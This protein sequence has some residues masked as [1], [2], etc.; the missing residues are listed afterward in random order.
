M[1]AKGWH[2]AL[3]TPYL[4][5]LIASW[6]VFGETTDDPFITFRYA[7]NICSGY[8]P[9]YNIGEHVEG[10]TSALH[11]LFCVL[12][13]VLLPGIG[14]LLKAKLFSLGCGL[15]TI[16]LTG[17]LASRLH[18]SLPALLAA[19]MLLACNI[20]FAIA[21][22][23]ALETTLFTALLLAAVTAFYDELVREKGNLSSAL[24]FLACLAR[25]EALVYAAALIAFRC[26][27]QRRKSLP[28]AFVGQWLL[29]FA[30]PLALFFCFRLAYYGYLFPNTYYAKA[31]AP[32]YGI[33]NGLLYLRRPFLPSLGASFDSV[34][35]AV[36]TIGFWA[37][38]LAGFWRKRRES[39]AVLLGLL[40]LGNLVFLL[41][42][43]GDW[44]SGCRFLIPV[45][46]YI[47]LL[48]VGALTGTVQVGE[49]TQQRRNRPLRGIQLGIAAL[50]MAA[51]G[52]GYVGFPLG[53]W[54]Q[55]GMPVRDDA[56]LATAT[57]GYAQTWVTIG[58]F[59]RQAMPPGTQIAYSEAGYAAYINRD[60]RFLD[61]FGLTD[62]EIAHV[63]GVE[64]CS[65]GVVTMFWNPPGDPVQGILR[66]RAPD[67]VVIGSV[68]MPSPMPLI[69]MQDYEPMP[70]PPAW[71]NALA[72]TQFGFYRR[73]KG[74]ISE[75]PVSQ[76]E[77]PDFILDKL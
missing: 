46:P 32:L 11:L 77:H 71:K 39:S 33:T 26:V 74:E 38:A 16:W 29:C 36:L 76:Y 3:V 65:F 61:T 67:F 44:M 23:N 15:A 55:R 12:L 10:F 53:R 50:M 14:M 22:V 75:A 37:L 58:Q 28:K 49:Q 31:V 59:F 25:P 34:W 21:S 6:A 5:M 68:A 47:T 2:L 52:A 4:V 17:R 24:L 63:T 18:A 70:I 56:L 20:N 60:K 27:W 72:E 69:L 19:Q 35:Q 54:A 73:R 66:R 30:A 45:L 57:H 9:V 51:L 8:G 43:G 42:S 41:K 1:K 62:R 48:Q 7:A 13:Y 40:I 64:R